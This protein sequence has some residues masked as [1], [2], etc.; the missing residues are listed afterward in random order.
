MLKKRAW[1]TVPKK[2]PKNKTLTTGSSNLDIFLEHE[3]G[4]GARSGSWALQ[5]LVTVKRW[6]EFLASRRGMGEAAATA[7]G[8]GLEAAVAARKTR[9]FS[10]ANKFLGVALYGSQAQIQGTVKWML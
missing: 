2:V 4:G 3:A 5:R 9:N 6:G 1:S 10:A 7:A 8:L